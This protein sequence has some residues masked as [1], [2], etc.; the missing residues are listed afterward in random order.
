MDSVSNK[1]ITCV[2]LI[3]HAHCVGQ[4]NFHLQFTPAYRRGVFVESKVREI[5]RRY[6]YEK[7]EQLGLVVFAVEFGPD[8][9][10]LFIGNCRKCDVPLI[11]HDLKGGSSFLVRRECRTELQKYLWGSKFW[12]SGYFYESVGNVTSPAIK[13][14][15]ERQQGKHWSERDFSGLP[16]RED[17]AQTVLSQFV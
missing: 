16:F 8:H 7:A 17:W 1:E 11:V 15:I 10:H 9:A 6:F 4:S 13:F 2:T 3:R 14:Y 12:S 5:C